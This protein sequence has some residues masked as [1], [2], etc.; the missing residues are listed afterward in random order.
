LIVDSSEVRKTL[1]KKSCEGLSEGLAI[2]EHGGVEQAIWDKVVGVHRN[3]WCVEEHLRFE[4]RTKRE[5]LEW[6]QEGIY[7]GG[8]RT[9]D[10]TS[11]THSTSKPSARQRDMSAGDRVEL[12]L[13]GF[14]RK[15]PFRRGVSLTPCL[16]FLHTD[17]ISSLVPGPPPWFRSNSQS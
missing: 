13:K 6:L 3:Q 10:S 7:T 14:F 5:S 8:A 2:I 17:A 4:S 15:I 11:N 1:R 12:S 9:R 16:I